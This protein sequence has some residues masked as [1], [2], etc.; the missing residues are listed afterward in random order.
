MFKKYFLIVVVGMFVSMLGLPIW[1]APEVHEV[2]EDVEEATQDSGI[3]LAV[4]AKI[5]TDKLLSESNIQVKT[6][7]GTVF[8]TGMVN[9]N[10]EAET[11][12]ELA[13]SVLGVVDVDASNLSIQGSRH[14][15]ADSLI[16]AKIKGTYIK[17]KI[18]S[19]KP[20][21]VQG[22]HV[23]TADGIVYLTGKADTPAQ[24]ENAE[25]LAKSIRGVKEVKS[26]IS[27]AGRS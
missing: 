23:E 19:N 3:T 6:Q 11:A 7:K 22:I 21:A 13:S 17:E 16:T 14:P 15:L 4:K 24:A 1:A 8:L 26:N 10:S 25:K 2:I 20:T 18:F 12:V 5:K 9:A 27:V